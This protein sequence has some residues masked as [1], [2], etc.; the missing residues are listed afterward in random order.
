MNDDYSKLGARSLTN[1]VYCPNRACEVCVMAPS[2]GGFIH[3]RPV[4]SY[5]CPKCDTFIEVYTD[6]PQ[7]DI[8]KQTVYTGGEAWI[9]GEDDTLDMWAEWSMV[10]DIVTLHV[11]YD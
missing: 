1:K 8:A 2:G 11:V 10:T 3:C 6:K 4:D 5:S 9:A 7:Y